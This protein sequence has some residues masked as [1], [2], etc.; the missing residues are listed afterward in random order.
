MFAS[1]SSNQQKQD[2]ESGDRLRLRLWLISCAVGAGVWATVLA[3]LFR[4]VISGL[5]LSDEALGLMRDRFL[6]TFGFTALPLGAL[7]YFVILLVAGQ[8]Q[9]MAALRQRLPGLQTPAALKPPISQTVQENLIA[10]L[11][12]EYRTP[13]TAILSSSELIERYGENWD[14]VRIDRHLQRIKTSV[15][16]MTALLNDTLLLVGRSETGPLQFEPALLNLNSFVQ[17]LIESCHV[18][19]QA[20]E[21]MDSELLAEPV[22]VEGD[23]KLVRSLLKALLSNALKFSPPDSKV[24][25]SLSYEEGQATF[26]IHNQGT[27]IPEAE[28]AEIFEPFYRGGGTKSVPGSGLGLPIAKVCAALHGGTL[29]ISSA[30]NEGT[31]ATVTLPM[32]PV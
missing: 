23:P 32:P 4:F 30:E 5:S 1:K 7:A 6:L 13:L 24:K 9:E 27:T 12:Q 18:L 19:E 16:A 20:A 28:R 10:L 26:V 14:K 3:L 25:L 31:T 21:R 17:D 8:Q 11:S 15:E 22:S 2:V 29:E